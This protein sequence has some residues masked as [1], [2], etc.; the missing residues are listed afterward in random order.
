M[1][2]RD[3]DA[4]FLGRVDAERQSCHRQEDRID[5]AQ[6]IVFQCPKCAQGKERA[7]YGGFVGVHSI[8]VFFS[9][10]QNA[11]VAPQEYDDNPRWEMSGTSLDDLTLSPSIDLDVPENKGGCGWHGY[12]R[13]GDAS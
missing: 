2:L 7:P 1:R 13:N 8:R 6:G 11:P 4:Q 9:N 10:P 5:G 3:L 12:V